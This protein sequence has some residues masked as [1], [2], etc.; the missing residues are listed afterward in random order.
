MRNL[1]ESARTKELSS[2]QVIVL[3]KLF[4]GAGFSVFIFLVLRSSFARTIKLFNF[5]MTQPID[6]LI[7]Y[8]S[9]LF[10]N[11]GNLSGR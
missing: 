3:S 2:S 6:Y 8:S 7:I 9:Y 5:T 1:S 10:I 4:I 11:Y